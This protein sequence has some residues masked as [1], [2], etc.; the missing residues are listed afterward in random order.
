[1]AY[2]HKPQTGPPLV[3]VLEPSWTGLGVFR[4]VVAN[5][6]GRGRADSLSVAS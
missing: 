4:A 5:R 2:I 3:D 6:L 1:M